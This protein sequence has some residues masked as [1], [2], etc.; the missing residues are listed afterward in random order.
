MKIER[1]LQQIQQQ[2]N[3]ACARV[4]RSTTDVHIVAVTKSVSIERTQEALRAGLIHL[5]ENRPEG[6]LNKQEAIK[7]PAKWHYI[8]SL[9]TRKVKHVINSV[10][11]LHSLDRLSL[12]D[13]IQKR[14]ERTIDCFIQ[15]NVAGEE[16]KHGMELSEV[17]P[18]IESLRDHSRIRIIGLMTMAPHTQNLNII[19]SVFQSLKEMQLQLASKKFPHAPCSELSMGMSNDFE[20]AVEE[21]ATYLRIGTALVGEESEDLT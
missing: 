7:Q 11:V 10:H 18:F 3:Q 13:E 4:N 12:A 17:E 14:A 16:A 2:I 6:L 5:G 20:I 1:N 9:Q 19:R 8:G 15:V 21:G